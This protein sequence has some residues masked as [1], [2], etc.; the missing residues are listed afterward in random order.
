MLQEIALGDSER[1]VN[2]ENESRVAVGTP[3]ERGLEG[4]TMEGILDPAK[5]ESDQN[6]TQPTTTF[7]FQQPLSRHQRGEFSKL[8]TPRPR[9]ATYR[10]FCHRHPADVFVARTEVIV[11][12]RGAITN[13]NERVQR[14]L[15]S[16]S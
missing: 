5:I 15:L 4:G 9:Y 8:S 2:L 14:P 3:M 1:E 16:F 6:T 7:T 12:H 10:S 11:L 13:G